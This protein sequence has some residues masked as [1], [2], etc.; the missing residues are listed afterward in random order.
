MAVA[1]VGDLAARVTFSAGAAFDDAAAG[2]DV[3]CRMPTEARIVF[4]RV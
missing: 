1:F 2:V 4:R 3:G